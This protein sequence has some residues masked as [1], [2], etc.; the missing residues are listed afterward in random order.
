[1]KCIPQ[2]TVNE[3]IIRKSNLL[4][5]VD[6]RF[7]SAFLMRNEPWIHSRGRQEI[8]TSS[9]SLNLMEMSS[10]KFNPLKDVKYSQLITHAEMPIWH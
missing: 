7:I 6:F 3:F 5:V 8:S 4:V 10:K 2:D 1:M 9:A